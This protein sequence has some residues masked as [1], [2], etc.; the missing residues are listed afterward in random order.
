[1]FFRCEEAIPLH[2]C[3]ESAMERLTNIWDR[4]GIAG[5]VRT[6]RRGVVQL[7]LSNL[8]EEMVKE[9][10]ALKDK[11]IENVEKFTIEIQHLSVELG[12]PVYKVPESIAVLQAEKDLRQK[13]ELLHKEKQD[14]MKKL[15]ALIKEDEELSME[16]ATLPYHILS[17]AV[18]SLQELKD[19]EQHIEEMEKEKRRRQ[20]IFRDVHADILS[21]LDQLELSP[22]TSFERLIVCESD[23]VTMNLDNLQGAQKYK[24]ELKQLLDENG[25]VIESM[26]E[27]VE[28]LYKR[29]EL[30]DD[31]KSVM[32][33]KEV[34]SS[35]KMSHRIILMVQLARLEK[36]KMQNIK[37]FIIESRKELL[38]IWDRCYICEEDRRKFTAF[39]ID[40]LTEELLASHEDELRRMNDYYNNNKEMLSLVA[41]RQLLWQEFLELERKANNPDRY[42]N[43][44]G[45]LL[46]EE[47]QRK[48]V[49]VD[50]PKVEQEVKMLIESWER[51]ND[52][53]FLVGG[54]AFEEFIRREK[55]NYLA[56]KENEKII[57]HQQKV[58]QMEEEVMFGSRP[59]TPCNK[60]FANNTNMTPSKTPNKT[61]KVGLFVLWSCDD[62]V[63]LMMV[64]D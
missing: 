22:N 29:L 19:F 49:A 58:R 63:L 56:E 34:Q 4:I 55:E 17:I 33:K 61:R 24:E 50:L 27:K 15:K 18:P 10:D 25:D 1:M 8:L 3:V 9:E 45:N 42:S 59:A 51:E 41:R 57:R 36:L 32:F 47:K 38:H 46:K 44:G 21:L 40:D 28:Q 62:F 14:R 20:A 6:S 53:K 23:S 7:H 64:N 39:Y 60:R 54:V 2:E 37:K 31:E 11:L 13:V 52:R 43:R 5:D 26:M 30:A 12:I 48:K 35:G 16:L